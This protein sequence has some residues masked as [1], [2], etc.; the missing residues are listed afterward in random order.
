M[1]TF[2]KI[3]SSLF[4]CITCIYAKSAETVLDEEDKILNLVKDTYIRDLPYPNILTEV[5]NIEYGKYYVATM[6][7][8]VNDYLGSFDLGY[9]CVSIFKDINLSQ[10]FCFSGDRIRGITD[11][12]PFF[13]IQTYR[14]N[15]VGYIVYTYLT[16]KLINDK[17]Y[18]HQY[19]KEEAHIDEIH[20]KEVIDKTYIYYRQPKDDPKKKNLI[21][22]DSVN[23]KL[24]QTLQ[25]KYDNAKKD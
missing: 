24:L 23:D 14:Q 11:K 18:L 9:N 1:K 21:P 13:T 4:L 15:R 2:L 19:S 20:I 3:L 12:L 7:N 17:F 8:Y 6:E 5:Y 10:K 25:E 22:L 16:F